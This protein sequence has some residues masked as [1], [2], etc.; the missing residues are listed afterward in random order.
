VREF[1]YKKLANYKWDNTIIEY[2][3]KIHEMKGRQELYLSQKQLELD[4]LVE[5][6][7]IQ[8]TEASNAIEGIGTTEARLKQLILQKTTPR[9]RNEKEIAGYRDA[10]ATIHENFLY[11]NV[12][13]NYILQLHK[14][15]Y[16]HNTEANFGGCFKNSQNEI[17]AVDENGNKTVLFMPL[18]SFETP[19]AIENLCKTFKDATIDGSVD[20]L[21]LIPIFIHDFLCIH[22]FRDGNGRMSRLLTTLL[23]YR[24]GYFVGKYISLESKIAKYKD[25][26]YDA[27]Y[28]SQIGWH[29]GKDDPTPFIKYLLMTILSAYNDFEE[30]LSL[31]GKKQTSTELVLNAFK[32]KIG[33]LTKSDIAELCPTISVSAVEKAIAALI[34]EGKVE[35]YG[36]GKNTYYVLIK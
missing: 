25:L 33:K 11:I 26:Y 35:K 5:I 8:S 10:L 2:I 13:P 27:L 32:T 14:I 28:D 29:E 15:L 30:R 18:A 22:P 36:Q 24:S 16:S 4:R 6:A 21:I 9:N 7:K 34:K 1:D 12:T 19:M 20:A 3:A 23:L 17:S 31:V